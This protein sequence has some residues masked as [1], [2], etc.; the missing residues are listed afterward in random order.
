MFFGKCHGYTNFVTGII[1]EIGHGLVKNV[2]CCFFLNLE[3]VVSKIIQ[4]Q[5]KFWRAA[6]AE[7]FLG[8]NYPSTGSVGPN[9]FFKK[10]PVTIFSMSR[11]AFLNLCHG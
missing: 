11:V 7:N 2:T 10:M 9:Q 3:E 6:G 4:P 1:F 5:K 8:Q